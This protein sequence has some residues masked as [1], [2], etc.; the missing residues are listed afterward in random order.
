MTGID[1]SHLS[2][3]ERLDLIGE[4]WDSIDAEAIPLTDAQAA[5]L[6]RRVA[7]LDANP[8]Q[9][10]DAREVLAE[11]RARYPRCGSP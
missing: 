2:P 6:D 11:F 4:I 5:E 9:G 10:H 7:M 1:Y 3:A 8:Q